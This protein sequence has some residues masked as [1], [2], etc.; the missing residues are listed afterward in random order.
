MTRDAQNVDIL[1]LKVYPF[2]E[3]RKQKLVTELG[4][5]HTLMGIWVIWYGYWLGTSEWA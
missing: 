2:I 5:G 3:G 1:R 4:N